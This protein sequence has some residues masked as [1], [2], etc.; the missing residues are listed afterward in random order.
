MRSG[1]ASEEIGRGYARYRRPDPAISQM[2]A[3]AL[4]ESRA[5][6]SIG[7]GTGSYEPADRSVVAVE[8]SLV[9]IRQ[10]PSGAAPAICA[11]AESLPLRSGSFD[12]ALAMLT[13]HHWSDVRAGLSEMRRVARRQIVL[14]FDPIAHCEHWLTE[15]VP[16][17]AD[18]F[19]AA[20]AV[21]MVADAIEATEIRT[22]PL[23][24]DTPDGMTIAYWRRPMAYLDP[25]RRASGSALQL[26]DAQALDR[27]LHRLQADLTSGAWHR[28]YGE[29]LSAEAMDY[30]LRLLSN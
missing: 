30:G 11:I 19:R 2:V 23:A 3:D 20:P 12:A 13:I 24:H 14:T 6:V 26:V 1:Q 27:G 7:S 10:R 25:A 29:L 9:M 15:Y 22:V 16:E 5:A 21:D 28:R 8:P 18:I 17:I 4:G